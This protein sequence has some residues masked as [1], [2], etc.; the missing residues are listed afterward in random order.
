MSF[1]LACHYGA[2][3]LLARTSI[4][5]LARMPVVRF[6][7]TMTAAGKPAI[8][9][10]LTASA[11]GAAPRT[12]LTT[13]ALTT[14]CAPDTDIASGPATCTVL[15]HTLAVPALSHA[16]ARPAVAARPRKHSLPPNCSEA[17][18][19]TNTKIAP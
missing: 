10:P 5:A 16:A 6:E 9:K 2:G 3:M 18:L 11:S 1:L 12:G 17:T 4:A 8:G 15:E 13:F 14:S 7:V 19:L